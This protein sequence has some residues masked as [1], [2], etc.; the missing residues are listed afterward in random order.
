MIDNTVVAAVVSIVTRTTTI[1]VQHDLPFLM[2]GGVCVSPL[3]P[4]SCW[5]GAKSARPT[6]PPFLLMV[7]AFADRLAAV[8]LPVASLACDTYLSLGF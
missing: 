3:K 1:D 7:G 4:C 5:D 8:S 6:P 2:S